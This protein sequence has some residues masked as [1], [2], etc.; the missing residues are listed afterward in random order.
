[1]SFDVE[2][3]I[4]KYFDFSFQEM[5]EFDQPALWE[6]VLKTTGQKK[7]TYIGHSQGTT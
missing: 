3:N 1:M 5:A 4:E 2:D 7:L 6:Y